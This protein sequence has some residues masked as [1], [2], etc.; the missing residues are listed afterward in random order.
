MSYYSCLSCTTFFPSLFSAATARISVS[1]EI[2]SSRLL[3]QQQRLVL[4]CRLNCL[5]LS[6]SLSD[7]DWVKYPVPE[8]YKFRQYPPL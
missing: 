3:F 8:K 2:Q 1:A 5:L 7:G 4:V 6:Y